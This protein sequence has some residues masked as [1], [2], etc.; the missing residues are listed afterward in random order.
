[1]LTSKCPICDIDLSVSFNANQNTHDIVCPDKDDARG[2]FKPTHYFY[3]VGS[4]ISDIH[5]RII[6]GEYLIYNSLVNGK[7]TSSIFETTSSFN[8]ECMPKVIVKMDGVRI[9]PTISKKKILTYI[10]FS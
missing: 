3:R 2:K 7:L 9:P 10:T 5:E 4:D 1:M 6:I 8:L